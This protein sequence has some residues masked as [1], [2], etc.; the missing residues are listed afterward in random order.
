MFERHFN[1]L[2]TYVKAY[3]QTALLLIAFFHSNRQHFTIR[4]I[5]EIA[6]T[7]NLI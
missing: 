4:K 1:F 3:Q 7:L 2:K 6:V 5:G